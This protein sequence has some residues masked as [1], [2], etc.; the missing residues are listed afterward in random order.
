MACMHEERDALGEKHL[1]AGD[2]HAWRDRRSGSDSSFGTHV[3]GAGGVSE[4]ASAR[5]PVD[6]R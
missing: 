6:H 3:P 5:S 4:V 2:W 1:A